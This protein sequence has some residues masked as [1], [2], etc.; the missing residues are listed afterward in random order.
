MLINIGARRG[1]EHARGRHHAS[2]Q[3]L[4]KRARKGGRLLKTTLF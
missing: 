2:L 4:W 1:G 3:F